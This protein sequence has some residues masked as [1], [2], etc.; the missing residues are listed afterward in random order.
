MTRVDSNLVVEVGALRFPLG[1]HP[2]VPGLKLTGQAS[3]A[4]VVTV[5]VQITVQAITN[6]AGGS[7]SPNQG[8]VNPLSVP[9]W[10]RALNRPELKL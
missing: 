9:F 5:L 6:L 3:R 8:P 2:G 7:V 4:P 10:H 1:L